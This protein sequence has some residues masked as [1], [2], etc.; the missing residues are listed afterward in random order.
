M[1]G[2]MLEGIKD[3]VQPWLG[4]DNWQ[5]HSF[6]YSCKCLKSHMAFIFL[7]LV[8]S[9]SLYHSTSNYQDLP[10]EAPSTPSHSVIHHRVS[11]HQ[12]ADKAR[13]CQKLTAR[14]S[15]TQSEAAPLKMFVKPF[16]R[17]AGLPCD[18]VR[19]L[20]LVHG[21]Q[22]ENISSSTGWTTA[23]GQQMEMLA[24]TSSASAGDSQSNVS[25]ISAEITFTV[26]LF[27]V[28]TDTFDLQHQ[29]G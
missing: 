5:W 22:E 28:A 19:A 13:N 11:S 29:M 17:A 27:V 16:T 15:Y 26:Q 2:I 9:S 4:T 21:L 8:P 1:E 23:A 18:S 25:Q 14:A 24:A 12:S 10:T 7:L 20:C 3:A 6:K